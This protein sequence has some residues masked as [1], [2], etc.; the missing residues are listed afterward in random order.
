MEDSLGVRRLVFGFEI[1][2]Y[3]TGDVYLKRF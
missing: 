3:G 1:D 2:G